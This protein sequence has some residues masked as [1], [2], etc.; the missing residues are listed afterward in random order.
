VSVTSLKILEQISTPRTVGASPLT[1]STESPRG[2]VS[3]FET[4]RIYGHSVRSSS[5][6]TLA[7]E[8]HDSPAPIRPFGLSQATQ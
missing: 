8:V 5:T 1:I 2:T 3:R 4:V 7:L 6:S